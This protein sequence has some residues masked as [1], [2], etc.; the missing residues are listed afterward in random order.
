MDVVFTR[1]VFFLGDFMTTFIW[2]G[3]VP[4]HDSPKKI[5]R[6]LYSYRAVITWVEEGFTKGGFEI[7]WCEY[8]CIATSPCG[9]FGSSP[10]KI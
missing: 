3:G 6:P 7:L 2:G 5:H 8:L 4:D 10:K 9:G 1:Y